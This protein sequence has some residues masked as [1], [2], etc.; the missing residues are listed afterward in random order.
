MSRSGRSAG[1]AFTGSSTSSPTIGPGSPIRR[2]RNGSGTT[3]PLEGLIHI[4]VKNFIRLCPALV[5]TEAEIDEAVERLERA[6]RRAE[7]GFSARLRL[8]V[9]ELARRANADLTAG[10]AGDS[11]G[12]RAPSP[13]P[14]S[15]AARSAWPEA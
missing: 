15:P 7:S 12:I 9:L 13:S 8:L 4:A 14:G 6:I 5:I 3:R 11:A 1:S 10:A 2:W